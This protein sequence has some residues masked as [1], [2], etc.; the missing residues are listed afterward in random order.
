MAKA[1]DKKLVT[2]ATKVLVLALGNM[3]QTE[4]ERKFRTTKKKPMPRKMFCE[5]VEVPEPTAFQVETGAM[6]KLDFNADV[7]P[8]LSALECRNDRALATALQRVHEGLVEVNAFLK[9]F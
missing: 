6:L 7:R 5:K 3:L 9:S 2:E 1:N 4:R 8:Y